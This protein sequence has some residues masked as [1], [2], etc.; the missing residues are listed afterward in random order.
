MSSVFIHFCF[1][2]SNVKHLSHVDFNQKNENLVRFF[3]SFPMQKFCETTN[4]WFEQ[5]DDLSENWR[6]NFIW[7]S[8]C[9]VNF[10][11]H[12]F[13]T[14]FSHF[15]RMQTNDKFY[16]IRVICSTPFP[17]THTHANARTNG[18]HVDIF[19]IFTRFPIFKLCK[20]QKRIALIKLVCL[21]HA[22]FS[23]LLGRARSCSLSLFST[24]SLSWKWT[25]VFKY[26]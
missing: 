10:I 25:S 11:Q 8:M 12:H 4:I 18:G 20:L 14:K 23:L 6:L 17:H 3:A 22:I 15:I 26:S 9:I 2:R 7:Q 21:S 19:I 5:Y 13:Q 24:F 16:F 1:L